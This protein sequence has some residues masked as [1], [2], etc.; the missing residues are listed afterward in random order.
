MLIFLEPSWSSLISC[1]A[2]PVIGSFQYISAA[3]LPHHLLSNRHCLSNIIGVIIL[4]NLTVSRHL[5]NLP[6]RLNELFERAASPCTLAR[7][8]LLLSLLSQPLFSLFS[9]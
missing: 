5:L 8:T 3:F 7:L 9:L 6:F 4:P 1:K 2:I